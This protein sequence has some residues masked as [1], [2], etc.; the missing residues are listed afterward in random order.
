MK[1]VL[2]HGPHPFDLL[3]TPARGEFTRCG[4]LLT[5]REHFFP[6]LSDA[7]TGERRK[8]DHGRRPS[9]RTRR[10]NMQCRAVFARR[11]FGALDIVAVRLVHGDHVGELDYA[12]FDAL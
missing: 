11:R 12:F 6:K 4:E 7:V 8:S 3:L 10:E 9:W 2:Q 1:P 5:M